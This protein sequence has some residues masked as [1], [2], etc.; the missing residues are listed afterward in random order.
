MNKNILREYDVRGKYPG[1]LNEET[2]TFYGQKFGS[3]LIDKGYE[4][5]VVGRDIRLSSESLKKNLIEGLLKSGINVID[6]GITSTPMLSYCSILFDTA[7]IEVT[8]SH[9]PPDENGFKMFLKQNYALCADALR[10]FYDYIDKEDIHEG[11]GTIEEKNIL[12]DYRKALFNKINFGSRRLK[13]VVDPGNGVT[14]CYV[15]D[16][17]KDLPC[18]ITYICDEPDGNFPNHHPDPI[19]LE[20]TEML[21][22]KVKELSADFGIGYDGDGDRIG[23]VDN[24][25]NLMYTDMLM[26]LL[27]K[28]LIFTD[29]PK[30]TLFDVKC[31]PALPEVLKELGIEYIVY[32]TGAPLTKNKINEE[33]I[34]F[35]GEYSG[36]LVFRDKYVGID[37]GI[38]VTIRLIEALSKTNHTITEIIEE[39]PKYYNAG[40][41]KLSTPDEIKFKVVDKMLEHYKNLGCN[42][43]D[44]DGVRVEDPEYTFCFRAS[45]TGPN[46]T[47]IP[48]AKT[49]EK[50]KQIIDEVQNLY[51]EIKKDV[52]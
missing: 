52:K 27:W 7:A 32:K 17:F 46:I 37:D 44:I 31:S 35:G 50:L 39:V 3:W 21:R 26:I 41:I 34:M 45:N 16:L 6:V 48:H 14:A 15:K 43:V 30:M 23:V 49:E 13:I 24:E 22:N 36:H 47:F 42:I 19:V 38:Y 25:G 40:E 9:N 29:T 5:I 8:A 11:N 20:Y 12:E 10:E 18:D 2:A 4:K 33:N 28:C 51:E 1:D